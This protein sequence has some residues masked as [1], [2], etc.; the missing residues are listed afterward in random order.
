MIDRNFQ[1]S[2]FIVDSED[3]GRDIPVKIVDPFISKNIQIPS[4]LPYRSKC[5]KRVTP[6]KNTNVPKRA[7]RLQF[8]T[9]ARNYFLFRRRHRNQTTMSRLRSLNANSGDKNVYPNRSFH[10]S[11]L[12]SSNTFYDLNFSNQPKDN[13]LTSI[14]TISTTVNSVQNMKDP[15]VIDENVTKNYLQV[16]TKPFNS[17]KSSVDRF[18][19]LPEIV[20]PGMQPRLNKMNQDDKTR[21]HSSNVNPAILRNDATKPTMEIVEESEPKLRRFSSSGHIIHSLSQPISYV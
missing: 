4:E 21:R 19:N 20:Y 18:Q 14:D 13:T 10:K 6:P 2:Y 3:L 5:G 15:G 1:V 16:P 9:N 11:S 7:K 12:Y 8:A 17:T